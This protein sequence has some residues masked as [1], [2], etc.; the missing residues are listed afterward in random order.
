MAE[1]SSKDAF[2]DSVTKDYEELK[3]ANK[4][5]RIKLEEEIE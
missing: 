5:R 2:L 4:K 3:E 1:L